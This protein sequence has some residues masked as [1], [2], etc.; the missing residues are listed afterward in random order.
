MQQVIMIENLARVLS[1]SD[2]TVVKCYAILSANRSENNTA[3]YHLHWKICVLIRTT[4]FSVF[5][6]R[7]LH[8]SEVKIILVPLHSALEFLHKR[9]TLYHFF[10]AN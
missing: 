7:I 6:Y 3:I 4:K 10:P 9:Q 5:R 1:G 8:I 2:T